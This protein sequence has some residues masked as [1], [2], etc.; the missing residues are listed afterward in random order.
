MMVRNVSSLR[1]VRGKL[2]LDLL[3]GK[4]AFPAANAG[5]IA[6]TTT[7]SGNESVFMVMARVMDF[8]V[9]T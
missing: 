6:T 9:R 7:T 5:S 3:M 2:L 8:G 1:S 4:D